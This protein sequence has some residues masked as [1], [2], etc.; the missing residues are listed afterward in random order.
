M[1]I[2]S[3]RYK[4]G[5]YTCWLNYGQLKIKGPYQNIHELSARVS[6]TESKWTV[7]NSK[8]WFPEETPGF[9]ISEL[10]SLLVC[11]MTIV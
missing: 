8:S 2:S 6:I 5:F 4:C 9:D 11:E 7:L 1:D 3:L 10:C